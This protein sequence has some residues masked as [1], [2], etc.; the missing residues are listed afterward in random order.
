QSMLFNRYLARRIEIGLSTLMEGEVVR[1]HGTG[2]HFTVGDVAAEQPRLDA[3]DLWLTGPMFGPKMK[4]S[5]AAVRALE[6][7]LIASAGLSESAWQRL[8]TLAPGTR[9]DLI[10]PLLD[11]EC[12]LLPDSC[13]RLTFS[14]PAG[15]YATRVITELTHGDARQEPSASAVSTAATV[16]GP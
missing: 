1:L 5:A 7:E 15:G 8:A 6:E 9:R 4:P 10:V 16:T 12:E 3:R 13:C 2:S 14:L 11:L